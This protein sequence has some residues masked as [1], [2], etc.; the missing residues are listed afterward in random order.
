[1]VLL[2]H[3]ILIVILMDAGGLGAPAR[4]RSAT[5]STTAAGAGA[6]EGACSAPASAHAAGRSVIVWRP[7]RNR[8]TAKCDDAPSR[9]RWRSAVRSVWR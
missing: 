5:P 6:E 3:A 1:M 4:R 2:Y 9:L 7:Q 8:A